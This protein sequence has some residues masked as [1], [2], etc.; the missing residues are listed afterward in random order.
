M[1][2]LARAPGLRAGVSQP[3]RDRSRQLPRLEYRFALV[4]R[5]ELHS[6]PQANW[7][8]SSS[9]PRARP[10]G[11]GFQ[12]CRMA[13]FPTRATSRS[14]LQ[15]PAGLL[16]LSRRGNLPPPASRPGSGSALRA[17]AHDVVRSIE[18]S[19]ETAAGESP[20]PKSREPVNGREQTRV[21]DKTVP[22]SAIGCPLPSGDA[23]KNQSRRGRWSQLCRRA[24]R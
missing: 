8:A 14:L 3:D 2:P 15:I 20:A 16:E 4:R 6:L 23:E 5:E 1:F 19:G 22:R 17:Q 7:P 9:R 24:C 10:A 13:G 11:P 21:R 18:L 12:N